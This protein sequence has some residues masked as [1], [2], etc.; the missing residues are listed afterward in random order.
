[1]KS[2]LKL[3]ILL[4]ILLV[5]VTSAYQP[6]ISVVLIKY[7]TNDV[8]LPLSHQ[9]EI[10]LNTT[11]TSSVNLPIV[12]QNSPKTTAVAND[13]NSETANLT[14][15]I[16][17]TPTPTPIPPQSGS[18]NIPIVLGALAIITVVVFA[19]FFFYYLPKKKKA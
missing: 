5:L 12:E 15:G 10:G 9:G 18:V 16:T 8:I 2:K 17:A 1:M 7:D 6:F 4:A 13:V 11:T 19:W 3:A 14:P